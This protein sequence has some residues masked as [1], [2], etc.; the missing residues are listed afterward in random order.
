[1]VIHAEAGASTIWESWEGP[2][3][4]NGLNIGSLNHYSKGAVVEWLFEKMCGIEIQSNNEFTITPHPGGHFTNAKATYISVY[5]EVVSEFV[6]TKEGYRYY[7]EIPAN[8][9]ASVK[10]LDGRER[11]LEPGKHEL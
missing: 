4:Q 8:T 3:S 2:D 5:G 1:M 11:I 9:T 6:K 10:L 7:F